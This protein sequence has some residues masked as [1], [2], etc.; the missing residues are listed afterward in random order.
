[1]SFYKV[2]AYKPATHT[3]THRG[4]YNLDI[5]HRDL[6]KYAWAVTFPSS[7]WTVFLNSLH[8]SNGRHTQTQTHTRTKHITS[9]LL[10]LWPTGLFWNRITGLLRPDTH[11]RPPVLQSPCLL[12]QHTLNQRHVCKQMY[13]NT[14]V[15]SYS[16]VLREAKRR[17]Y[18]WQMTPDL[19]S[20]RESGN[21]QWV[22]N[23]LIYYVSYVVS[24][25]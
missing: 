8:V 13:T 19:R 11:L 21:V 14:R 15:A 6:E 16:A 5:A 7:N 1:M 4:H 17:S 10:A 12:H 22:R 24:S 23:M 9:F 2:D 25:L 20:Y 3:H 18:L